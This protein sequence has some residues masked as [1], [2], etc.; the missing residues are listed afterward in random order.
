MAL[1]EKIL[2]VM[3]GVHVAA[4]A[5]IAEG[6]PAVR[7]M[8]LT[9]LDDLT[10]IGSTMTASRK[11]AQIRKN[12]E[13]ALSIWSCKEFSDP[14]V[15]IQAKCS[16]HEDTATKKQY[17]NPMWEEYFKTPENPEFVVL[18]FAP[19]RIEYNVPEGMEVWEK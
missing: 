5:T 19:Y 9:G 12:P 4:V 10:L 1:K 8:A 7:Y 18:K 14:Y 3:G 13:V 17:W 11:V 6:K 2:P 15:V 16:V